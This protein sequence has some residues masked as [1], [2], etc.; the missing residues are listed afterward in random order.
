MI[1]KPKKSLGQHFL[2]DKNICEKIAKLILSKSSSNLL[3]VGP[4]TGAISD[5]LIQDS[6]FNCHLLEI[7]KESYS[8][9]VNKYPN[10]LDKIHLNDF[11]KIDI[12]SFFQNEYFS[13]V[14]NFPYNISSQILFKCIENRNR[15]MSITGMFQKEVAER[16]AEKPGSKKYGV[17][18]VFMQAFY[19]IEYCFTISPNVFNPPPKVDSGVIH[20]SRNKVQNLGCD[21]KLFF[22]VVKAA[23]NQRRKTLRNSLKSFLYGIDTKKS[24]FDKRPETLRVKDF[25]FIV[26]LVSEKS[27][28]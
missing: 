6:E 11:L 1:V 4:G 15:V 13:V 9:L 23:F 8:Y 25:V 12:N 2:L 5:Y 18:S 10:K 3:E 28:D 17:L 19:D 27:R 20:C 22:Q 24:I 26:L 7:D 14:G 21:E 16:I